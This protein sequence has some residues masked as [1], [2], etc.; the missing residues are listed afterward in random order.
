MIYATHNQHHIHNLIA[1]VGFITAAVFR[2][3]GFSALIC[4]MILLILKASPKQY[5]GII[6]ADAI[7]ATILYFQ[8]GF[9]TSFH[10]IAGYTVVYIIACVIYW[11]IT[12]ER[13]ASKA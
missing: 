6:I 2:A 9:Y 11:L 5:V 7:Y 8:D 10:K 12:L 13:P 1:L 4:A 3:W